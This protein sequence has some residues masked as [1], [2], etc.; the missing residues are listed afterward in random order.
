MCESRI[1]R[2][3]EKKKNDILNEEN[4]GPLFLTPYI[5]NKDF[6]TAR[7]LSRCGNLPNT[8]PVESYS[9]LITVNKEYNSNLFFWFFPAFVSIKF[10]FIYTILDSIIDMF[11]L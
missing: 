2:S 4:D 11:I 6:K 10:C 5:E 1:L 8:P 9:G 7:E 3:E